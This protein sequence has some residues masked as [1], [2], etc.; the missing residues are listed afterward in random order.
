MARTLSTGALEELLGEW[1]QLL[2]GWSAD[3]SLVA[4]AREA[5][6]LDRKPVL[7]AALGHYC[8]SS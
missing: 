6:R 7:W 5:L 1:R 3:G 8:T 2:Q 4:A